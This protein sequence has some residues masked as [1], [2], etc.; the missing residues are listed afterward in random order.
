MFFI[1][2]KLRLNSCGY[3]T[4]VPAYFY[5]ITPALSHGIDQ[6]GVVNLT[7]TNI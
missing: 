1:R 7:K 4:E 6:V 5:L 2:E 3:W